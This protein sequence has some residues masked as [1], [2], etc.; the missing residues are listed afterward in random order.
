LPPRSHTYLLARTP[1]SSLAH[2]PPRSHTYLLARTPTSS[3]ARLP[4]RSHAYLARPLADTS[5]RSI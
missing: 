5:N 2:L 3:L 4:S 1:T